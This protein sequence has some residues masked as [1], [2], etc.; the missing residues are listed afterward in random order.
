M[1][2]ESPV[3]PTGLLALFVDIEL[4]EKAV[5]IA[6]LLFVSFPAPPVSFPVSLTPLFGFF[7]A[8][9]L[10]HFSVAFAA[11]RRLTVP[12]PL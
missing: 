6:P 10:A 9:L 5:Y 1:E 8:D 4:P 3:E 7:L 11:G 12:L 2:D